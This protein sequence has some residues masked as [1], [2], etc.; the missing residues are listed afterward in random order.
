MLAVPH[1]QNRTKNW[2]LKQPWL[3]KDKLCE[4]LEETEEKG[5]R[6]RVGAYFGTSNSRLMCAC[7][8]CGKIWHAV[9]NPKSEERWDHW[10]V[11]LFLAW[12]PIE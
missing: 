4:H 9:R 10:V 2:H 3:K 7:L 12:N 5:I 8:T 11:D 6:E 1:G